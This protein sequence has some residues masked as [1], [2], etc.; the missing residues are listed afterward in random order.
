MQLLT[1][2]N[3]VS[4]RQQT[5]EPLLTSAAHSKCLLH[6]VI[7]NNND[8]NCTTSKASSAYINKHTAAHNNAHTARRMLVVKF[9]KAGAIIYGPATTQQ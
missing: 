5:A 9:P 1:I 2:V 6:A 4:V 3:I 8:T 7:R